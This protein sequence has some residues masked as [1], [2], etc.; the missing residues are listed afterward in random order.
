LCGIYWRPV[1][2]FA[3][4]SG[5]SAEDA[6]DLT[7]TFFAKLMKDGCFSKADPKKGKLRS[8]LIGA[9]K[10]HLVDFRRY[11]GAAKRGGEVELLPIAM[12]DLDFEDAEYHYAAQPMEGLTPDRIFEQSWA[13]DLLA[14]AHERV[15]VAY[16]DG[17][18]EKEYQLL[19]EV[20]TTTGE[21]DYQAAARQLKLT[22]NHVRVLAH[23][24]RKNFKAAAKDEI[25]ETVSS[26][27][28][29]EEELA[30]LFKVF[31]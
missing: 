4:H 11:E 3:R 12:S 9:L 19:K 23:R 20:V 5:L 6:E 18:K 17:G 30:H 13:L 25:G 27:S 26:F 22:V 1:Y 28:E 10:R 16:R 14:R 21:I 7:Q 8:F 15:R 2:A 31:S 29:V 24:L